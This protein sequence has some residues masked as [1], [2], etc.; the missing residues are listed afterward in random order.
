MSSYGIEIRNDDNNIIID[1]ENP[2]FLIRVLALQTLAVRQVLDTETFRGLAL[3]VTGRFWVAIFC[4]GCHTA[5]LALAQQITCIS[6]VAGHTAATCKDFREGGVE[7]N[8]SK[9]RHQAQNPHNL[10]GFK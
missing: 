5:R 7:L 3:V 6:S 8:L 2:Q 10:N 1:G 4:S 9:G